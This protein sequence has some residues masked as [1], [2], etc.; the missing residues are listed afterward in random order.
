MRIVYNRKENASEMAS[1]SVSL[2]LWTGSAKEHAVQKQVR[3]NTNMALISTLWKG[4]CFLFNLVIIIDSMSMFT[5]YMYEFCL[6][7]YVPI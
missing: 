5:I 7:T 6:C 3:N 4:S 1:K 2:A